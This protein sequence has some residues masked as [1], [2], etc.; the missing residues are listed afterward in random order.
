MR[1]REKA[2]KVLML[3]ADEIIV[4]LLL[5]VILP[6][7]GI[8]VPVA[9]VLILLGV[10]VGKDIIAAPRIWKDFERRVEV[11]PEALIGK[12]ATAITEL[13]PEGTV[14]IGNE[15][16][17]ARCIRGHAMPGDRVKIVRTEGTKLLV[18][19]RE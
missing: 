9:A 18:E 12:E 14:K 6:S 19:R 10:L 15:F 11:G 5:L 17:S 2:L 3:L 13:N 16:W 1:K 8:H 4:G 7:I